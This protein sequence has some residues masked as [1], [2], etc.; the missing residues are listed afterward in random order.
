MAGSECSRMGRI[1]IEQER[2]PVK[3]MVNHT[4][5]AFFQLPEHKARSKPFAVISYEFLTSMCSHGYGRMSELI[6]SLRQP[7]KSL[8]KYPWI[9]VRGMGAARIR[10]W[11]VNKHFNSR[12]CIFFVPSAPSRSNRRWS[13]RWTSLDM[14]ESENSSTA[15]RQHRQAPVTAQGTC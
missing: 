1:R 6:L 4:K 15:H 3:S 9:E 12:N 7:V 11:A 10:R 2:Q 14:H 13:W 8:R 5:F